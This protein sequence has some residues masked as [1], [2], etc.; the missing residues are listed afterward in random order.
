MTSAT[1]AARRAYA[2]AFAIDEIAG[3][4]PLERLYWALLVGALA[5]FSAWLTDDHAVADA[6]NPRRSVPWPWFTAA[7]HVTSLAARLVTPRETTL[8]F[9]ALFALL[10]AGA[11]AAI[12]RRWAIAHACLLVLFAFEGAVCLV[13][14][15]AWENLH[16]HHLVLTALFL[17]SPH[18]LAIERRAVVLL[19][20][21]SGTAK[22][23]GGWIAGKYFHAL[24]SGLPL[25]PA[26]AIPVATNLAIGL[27]L[28]G[29]FGLLSSNARVQRAAL[30]AF[31][32]FHAYSV[33]LV[34]FLYPTI[35]VGVL[36]AVFGARPAPDAVPAD[37]RALPALG[38]LALVVFGHALRFFVP[39]ES[40]TTA[41]NAYGVHMF[42]ANHQCV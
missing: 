6:V 4:A 1:G 38:L 23:T 3:C 8:V 15:L 17:F 36:L 12:E 37:R 2:R 42:D 35:V 10:A 18:K 14:A 41:M 34:G 19:Y 28:V 5:T 9:I 39:D 11:W 30:A 40:L 29:A 22:L 25:V 13:D 20:V 27:E 33:A 21:L 16:L 7:E 32:A 24:A 26:W 31:V